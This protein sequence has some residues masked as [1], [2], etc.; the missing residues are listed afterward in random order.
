MGGFFHLSGLLWPPIISRRAPVIDGALTA[1]ISIDPLIL[2]SFSAFSLILSFRFP[3]LLESMVS[4]ENPD[5]YPVFLSLCLLSH[6]DLS[7]SV[8]FL[9]YHFNVGECIARPFSVFLLVGF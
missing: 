8:F 7:S 3:A 6:C 1:P 5:A 2:L 4:W 9:M